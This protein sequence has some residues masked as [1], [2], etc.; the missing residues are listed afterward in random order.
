MIDSVSFNHVALER[1][2]PQSGDAL[3]A[4]AGDRQ[5]AEHFAALMAQ[6]DMAAPVV[7]RFD[8]RH[9][10]VQLIREQNAQFVNV[11]RNMMEALAASSM[12]DMKEM[13]VRTMQMQFELANM[14]MDLA[15]KMGVVN[16]SKSAVETLMK[17]Q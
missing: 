15:A 10:A 7:E 12:S 1:V 14:Q 9:A 6:P 17:N 3:G 13:H 4:P 16:S 5:L 2:G 11:N 8:A